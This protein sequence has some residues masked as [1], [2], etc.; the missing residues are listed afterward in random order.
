MQ[1]KN[2]LLA[3]WLNT[4]HSIR[5]EFQMKHRLL[6]VDEI[7]RKMQHLLKDEAFSDSIYVLR[8]RSKDEWVPVY[9]GRS[10]SPVSRWKSHLAGLLKGTGLYGRWR[11]LLLN[12]DN[13]ALQDIE[14]LIFLDSYIVQPPIPAFPST[15]GSVEY[16]LVSLASDTYPDTLLNHE[17]NRR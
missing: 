16:Q 7:L 11:T 1:N 4:Q 14:L 10:S 9:I 15:I 8:I 3:Q 6:E 5:V 2:D 17:G 12:N 13:C